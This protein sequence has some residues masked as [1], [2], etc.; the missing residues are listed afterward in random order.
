M[1]KVHEINKNFKRNLSLKKGYKKY[2]KKSFN[3]FL[4]NL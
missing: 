1:F 4:M 3:V 2:F